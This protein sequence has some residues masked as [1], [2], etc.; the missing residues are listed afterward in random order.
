MLGGLIVWAVHFLGVYALASLADLRGPSERGLWRSAHLA[1]SLP[2]AAAAAALAVM[3]VRQIARGP[4]SERFIAR[5]AALGA[6]LGLVAIVWQSLPAL[7]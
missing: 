3:A 5:I 6:V 2:C 4:S 1:F 7:L